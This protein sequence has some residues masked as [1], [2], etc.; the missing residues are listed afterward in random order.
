M[1]S[2]PSAPAP[3]PPQSRPIRRSQVQQQLAIAALISTLLLTGC[4]NDDSDFAEDKPPPMVPARFYETTAQCEADFAQQ[5]QLA[6]SPT[7]LKQSHPPQP[8]AA[9]PPQPQSVPPSAIQKRSD[10][11][12]QMAAAKREHDRHAPVY[13][14]RED[15]ETDRVQYEATASGSSI[16]GFRPRFGGMY[17]YPPSGLAASSAQTE[18][19]RTVYRSRNPGEVVTPEGEVLPQSRPGLV[20]VPAHINHLAPS[21]PVNHAAK[22]TITGRSRN[23]FGSTYK[24]TGRGGK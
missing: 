19:P 4:Q 12:T 14:T 7:A 8:A 13:R 23:G 10:C 15:C 6:R 20:S 2:L 9:Q 3:D 21:R 17:L 24:S 22:G 11:D 5:Q 16:R 1:D 18:P